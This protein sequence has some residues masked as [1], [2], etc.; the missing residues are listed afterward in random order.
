[1]L[2]LKLSVYHIVKINI[3]N[4]IIMLPSCL[5]KAQFGETKISQR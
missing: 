5:M 2:F 3:D 1:M 4:L